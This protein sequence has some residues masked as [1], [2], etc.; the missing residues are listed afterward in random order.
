MKIFS[1]LFFML[2]VTVVFLVTP[3]SASVALD[4]NAIVPTDMLYFSGANSLSDGYGNSQSDS[5]NS[6]LKAKQSAILSELKLMGA[7]NLG[8]KTLTGDLNFSGK[9]LWSYPLDSLYS[10]TEDSSFIMSWGK[11][12][13]TIFIPKGVYDNKPV[14]RA[15]IS[16]TLAAIAS[17]KLAIKEAILAGGVSYSRNIFSMYPDSQVPLKDILTPAKDSNGK[18]LKYSEIKSSTVTM[19]Y[20]LDHQYNPLFGKLD[21]SVIT[22]KDF[23]WSSKIDDIK[24]SSDQEGNL[25]IELNPDYVTYIALITSEGETAAP[26]DSNIVKSAGEAPEVKLSYSS[27]K[28]EKTKSF[29]ESLMRLMVPTNFFKVASSETY[30]LKNEKSYSIIP[31]VRLLISHSYVYANAGKDTVFTNKGDYLMYGINDEDLV[32]GQILVDYAEDAKGK[33]TNKGRIVGAVIPLRYREAVFNSSNGESLLTGR[34]VKFG[35]DYPKKTTLDGLNKGLF[36][37]EASST[38]DSATAIRDFAFTYKSD[39]KI[40]IEHQALLA[41][42]E[43]F[44]LGMGFIVVPEVKEGGTPSADAVSGVKG[45]VMYRNNWYSS[46]PDLIL[47]LES[48]EAKKLVGVKAEELY[49]LLSGKFPTDHKPL[50]Y[51]QWTRLKEIRSE[52]DVPLRNKIMSAIRIICIIFGVF[53]LFYSVLLVLMYWIDIFNTLVDFSLLHFVTFSRLYPIAT[54]SD[55]IYERHGN[56]DVKYVTFGNILFLCLCGMGTGLIF[57]F[58]TPI[59]DLLLFMYDKITS[60]AGVV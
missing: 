4:G 14:N 47:W 56:G 55:L 51:E 52:L 22:A 40:A 38:G 13:T 45:F 16:N 41:D 39:Y 1:S 31:D 3:S 30:T 18:D 11:T 10:S 20:F 27:D 6:I 15:I 32:L 25:T 58:F 23:A 48:A 29:V 59:V 21:A 2:L 57:I 46:N 28:M 49:G 26:I 60:W 7:S 54:K 12:P 24:F 50:D 5:F 42:P 53:L 19:H 44:T 8:T 43:A 34:S 36:A 9:S 33:V 35:N 17:Y 37:L